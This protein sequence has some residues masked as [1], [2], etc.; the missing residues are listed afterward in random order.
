MQTVGSVRRSREDRF[1][2]AQRMA[3][4][5]VAMAVLYIGFM[6]IGIRRGFWLVSDGGTAYMMDFLP[7][8]SAGH[9]ALEG[10]AAGAYDTETI[11]AVERS[12]A[13]LRAIYPWPYPPTA[14]FLVVPFAMLPYTFAVIA[15]ALSTAVVYLA[16]I[17]TIV[18]RRAAVLTALGA[19]GVLTNFYIGQNG[20]LTAGLMGAS[21]GLLETSP[22]ISGI[23]LGL[24]TYKP[25]F[26]LLF[27]IVLVLTGRWRAF[28]SAA[29]T[30]GALAGA[31][32]L[33]FGSAAWH[34]FVA[35]MTSTGTGVLANGALGWYKVNSAYG[36]VR[37]LGGSSGLAWAVHAGVALAVTIF[38][39]R[40]W[41]RP[42]PFT[43]K[44]AALSAGALLVTPYVL[45][46]DYAVIAIPAAFLVAEG[47]RS[48]FMRG[49]RT[50]LMAAAV[51]FF[52]VGFYLLPIGPVAAL[53]LIAMVARRLRSAPRE[54]V[55]QAAL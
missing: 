54:T 19:P 1:F 6:A 50:A 43:L 30:A 22:V 7:M 31:S 5:G 10:N 35:S 20:L 29:I 25:H 17:Y 3:F 55:A 4:Y 13:D 45:I 41:L 15:W 2:K 14:L 8:W 40:L 48:G 11:R 18:P 46:Y 24:L 44:A 33:V 52:A 28:S 32:Y 47:L 36:V 27:P 21:L 9:L 34:G 51:A 26:G 12:A 16:G 53:G 23:F 38:V 42:A 37:W 39:C 49:E